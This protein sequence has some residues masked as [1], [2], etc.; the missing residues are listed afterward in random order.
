VAVP[1]VQAKG[2][3]QVNA[4]ESFLCGHLPEGMYT[5]LSRLERG[6]ETPDQSLGS[7]QFC[8]LWG[9]LSGTEPIKQSMPSPQPFRG[10]LVFFMFLHPCPLC[11]CSAKI[12]FLYPCNLLL[13]QWE[14]SK[15][16]VSAILSSSGA[17][18]SRSC[19][20]SSGLSSL[21]L[22][23]TLKTDLEIFCLPLSYTSNNA[24]L[25]LKPSLLL[26]ILEEAERIGNIEY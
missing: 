13:S 4:T 9:H 12:N 19:H 22:F 23:V 8:F 1:T 15:Q 17:A 11:R 2:E 24:S 7:Y 10:V 3:L 16:R 18:W 14:G 6:P 20:P 26:N 5:S 21:P 25:A